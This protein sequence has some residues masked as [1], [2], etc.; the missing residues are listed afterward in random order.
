MVW[1]ARHGIIAGL[2]GVVT[3]TVNTLSLNG[4]NQYVDH[5]ND[6]SLQLTSEFTIGCYFKTPVIGTTQ[7]LMGKW[8]SNLGYTMY[9]FSSQIWSQANGVGISNGVVLSSNTQYHFV[10][11]FDGSTLKIYIDGVLANSLAHTGL[12]DSGTNLLVGTVTTSYCNGS[13]ATPFVC[14]RALSDPE[15]SSIYNGGTLL[16]PWEYPL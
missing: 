10:A 4:S 11:S 9:L 12:T 8:A 5:G 14:D 1:P 13:M 2:G 3:P 6:A 7:S 15:V 16:Q